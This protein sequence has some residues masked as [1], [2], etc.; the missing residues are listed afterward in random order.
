MSHPTTSRAFFDRIYL[1][2]ADPW[3]FAS[4]EYELGR[5]EV[6]MQA[7]STRRYRHAFEPGCSI[8]VLTE[9][10]AT[11]CECVDAI[12]ISSTAVRQASLRCSRLSNVTIRQGALPTD[13]P[14]GTFDLLVLSEIGYYFDSAQLRSLIDDLVGRMS[15]GSVFLAV[16]WLGSSPDHI[17]SGSKVHEVISSAET[18]TQDLAENHTK[19]L[20]GRWVCK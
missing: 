4:S 17:L 7:L 1:Q 8:G 12:D 2:D 20:L 18:L 6:T 15:S 11:I 13:I 5:Y 14:A 9:R 16:H 3:R 19:F 10:L